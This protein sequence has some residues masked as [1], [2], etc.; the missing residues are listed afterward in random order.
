METDDDR[1]SAPSPAGSYDEGPRTTLPR[2]RKAVSPPITE[3]QDS[4]A[5]EINTNFIAPTKTCKQPS[6]VIQNPTITKNLFLPLSDSEGDEES[7]NRMDV[8]PTNQVINKINQQPTPGPSGVQAPKNGTSTSTKK[9]QPPIVLE[10]HPANIKGMLDQLKRECEGKFF[11]KIAKNTTLLYFQKESDYDKFESFF[12]ENEVNHHT[13]CKTSAKTHAFVLRGLGK[14]TE[15]QDVMEDLIDQGLPAKQVIMMKTKSPN[16]L[17]LVITSP[18]I[19]VKMLNTK[20]TIVCNIKIKWEIRKN[21][22]RIIQCRRCQKWGHATTNCFRTPACVKCAG[23]HLTKDCQKSNSDPPKCAN[24]AGEHTACTLTCPVYLYKL[25]LQ[26]PRSSANNNNQNQ[27]TRYVPAPPPRRPAWQIRKE[28]SSYK[29]PNGD[30]TDSESETDTRRHTGPHTKQ[31]A[32]N[33][34]KNA[35]HTRRAR[36]HPASSTSKQTPPTQSADSAHSTNRGQR[37][38]QSAGNSAQRRSIGKKEDFPPLLSQGRDSS[39]SEQDEGPTRRN[40][41]RSQSDNSPVRETTTT[42]QDF[43]S[44]NN[45]FRKLNN[46]INVKEMLKAINHLN[47][48]LENVESNVHAFEIFNNFM[49]TDINL[50]KITNNG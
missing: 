17:F 11:A 14:S 47:K 9:F 10:K 19:T 7:E 4:D 28:W 16:P 1:L 25:N 13:Y 45:A 12:R 43:E 39:E 30:A 46:L 8:P 35:G 20:F 42:M 18:E 49:T 21:E 48:K 41:T 2:K 32:D 50:F 15:E 31:H 5:P 40:N 6:K 3:E 38:M 22:R 26:N 23:A 33:T 37:G 44:L 27:E 36:D 24:C 34:S 29:D